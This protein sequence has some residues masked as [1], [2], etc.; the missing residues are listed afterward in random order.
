M[1]AKQRML[2]IALFLRLRVSVAVC[3]VA[4]NGLELAW[5]DG[6]V[7]KHKQRN[8]RVCKQCARHAA[9]VNPVLRSKKKKKKKEK[10]KKGELRRESG[11]ERLRE[12]SRERERGREREC[13][14]VCVCV[15]L[16]EGQPHTCTHTRSLFLFML[17]KLTCSQRST[18]SWAH[19]L[20]AAGRAAILLCPT[21]SSANAGDSHS[22]GNSLLK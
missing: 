1:G 6:V 3:L 11:R 15:R 8:A 19:W 12:R 7:V 13:V 21:F 4:R 5:C 18:L 22:A 9:H 2:S 14:C 10:K 16:G 17:S 20:K